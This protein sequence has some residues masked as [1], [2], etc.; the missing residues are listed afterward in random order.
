[1]REEI[2]KTGGRDQR[3]LLRLPRRQRRLPPPPA[4]SG[5]GQRRQR[6]RLVD[7]APDNARTEDTLSPSA[8][9]L[10]GNQMYLTWCD[11]VGPNQWAC[12]STGTSG[13]RRR[14]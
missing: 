5:S 11:A 2:L 7:R 3:P 1:G 13:L 14:R 6:S 8:T 4:Q 12:I 10:N 9:R